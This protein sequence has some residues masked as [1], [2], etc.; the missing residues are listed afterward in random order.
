ME[1]INPPDSLSFIT[2]Q[3]SN[4][5]GNQKAYNW[6]TSL[7]SK[8]AEVFCLKLVADR[9]MD[10]FFTYLNKELVKSTDCQ[11]KKNRLMTG[12]GGYY[13]HIMT[14]NDLDKVEDKKQ[15][16]KKLQTPILIV[17]GQCDNQKWGYTEEYLNLFANIK[18]KIIE[19]VGHDILNDENNQALT[20]ISE[21]VRQD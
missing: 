10:N 1:S 4:K 19:G 15:E 12:G 5:E 2:P 20:F 6:K 18:L 9:E 14:V 11:P 3:Y 13:S 8:F 7:V 17:K 21:F 16:L